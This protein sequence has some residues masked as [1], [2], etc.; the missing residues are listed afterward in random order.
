[1]KK[2]I[3]FTIFLLSIISIL[4]IKS[5][6]YAIPKEAIRLRVLA[7]SNSKYDQD[8]KKTV[9]DQIQIKMYNLLKDTKGAE[10]AR[11]IINRNM[12]EIE[13]EVK[14]TLDESNYKLGYKVNYG[15][16]YFPEKEFKGTSYKEGYYESLL[17]TLGSGKGDNWWCVLFPPLCL[18]EAEESDEVE[19]KFFIQELFDKYF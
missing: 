15:L 3:I 16:N 14:R 13:S 2:I 19:Y 12:P 8:I 4:N 9:S 1:M 5:D 11:K 17:I 6:V 7:N 10:E 18:V